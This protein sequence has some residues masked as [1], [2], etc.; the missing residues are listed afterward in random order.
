MQLAV[1]LYSILTSLLFLGC[2]TQIGHKQEEVGSTSLEPQHLELAVLEIDMIDSGIE[3]A[4]IQLDRADA[5]MAA[6]DYH[7]ALGAYNVALSEFSRLVL[8]GD[9]E[10]LVKVIQILVAQAQ[11]EIASDSEFFIYQRLEKVEKDLIDLFESDPNLAFEA[12]ASLQ[13]TRAELLVEYGIHDEAIATLQSILNR[14]GDPSSDLTESKLAL[15]SYCLSEIAEIYV[16]SGNPLSASDAYRQIIKIYRDLIK[17][18]DDRYITLLYSAKINYFTNLVDLGEW[19]I[20]ESGFLSILEQVKGRYDEFP[21]IWA[22]HYTSALGN[23]A[24]LRSLQGKKQY[25]VDL[26]FEARKVLS[27]LPEDQTVGMTDSLVVQENNLGEVLTQ[28]H[29]FAEAESILLS[30]RERLPLLLELDVEIYFVRS[31]Q[32]LVNLG[33]LYV[34]QHRFLEAEEILGLVEE[35]QREFTLDLPQEHLPL[36]G[37]CLNLLGVVNKNLGDFESA[38]DHFREASKISSHMVKTELG[39]VGSLHLDVGTNLSGLLLQWGRN[40]EGFEKAYR[41]VNDARAF[42]EKLPSLSPRFLASALQ[43]LGLAYMHLG[44]DENAFEATMESARIFRSLVESGELQYLREWLLVEQNLISRFLVKG[45]YEIP[46]HIIDEIKGHYRQLLS[47]ESD[48]YLPD[49]LDILILEAGGRRNLD[50]LAIALKVYADALLIYSHYADVSL[51]NCLKQLSKIHRGIG[52]SNWTLENYDEARL[53]YEKAI[54]YA[55]ALRETKNILGS[56]LLIEVAVEFANHLSR[57]G[58]RDSTYAATLYSEAISLSESLEIR[59]DIEF[60]SSLLEV[61]ASYGSA[62][63]DVGEVETGL[64]ISMQAVVDTRQAERKSPGTYIDTLARVLYVTAVSYIRADR[65]E[66]SEEL[67]RESAELYE[68][69][70][71][72]DS[73]NWYG[74]ASSWEKLGQ[75]QWSDQKLDDARS[76]YKNVLR[77]IA[78][79]N[80]SLKRRDLRLLMETRRSLGSICLDLDEAIDADKHWEKAY[81]LVGQLHPIG[82][83]GY[84]YTKADLEFQ[85]GEHLGMS[86]DFSAA[87]RRWENALKWCEQFDPLPKTLY[88]LKAIVHERLAAMYRKDPTGIFIYHFKSS[89]ELRSKLYKSGDADQSQALSYIHAILAGHFLEAQVYESAIKH[90]KRARYFLGVISQQTDHDVSRQVRAIDRILESAESGL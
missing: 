83:N 32:N 41:T 23:F 70:A 59:S 33:A 44:D 25:S 37:T 86:G 48:K 87:T 53:H 26:R 76:S 69:I 66:L 15:Y 81:E 21:R 80:G 57:R 68:E 64:S 20:A 84:N 72:I 30:A 67:L 47:L 65:D 1:V 46:F 9:S 7:N 16:E 75:I 62:L 54:E 58:V 77:S 5:L 74:A 88:E 45:E 13:I 12:L 89:S 34:A 73:A 43:N 79:L 19:A 51:E 14:I 90:G 11:I 3:Q 78:R 31:I 38:E 17:Y 24:R 2:Q 50:Q 60:L 42:A 22:Q 55:R 4:R 8:S 36:L 49:F 71:L 27:S 63:I 82:S 28:L 35:L 85:H 61:K 56:K 52:S 40:Q 18:D 29:R 6:G 39:S 10:Y